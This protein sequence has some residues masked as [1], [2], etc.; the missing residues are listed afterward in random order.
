VKLNS[1]RIL[2]AE[3]LLLDAAKTR[4]HTARILR[5]DKCELSYAKGQMK[6]LY[7]GRKFPSVDVIIPRASIT[8]N[9]DLVLP[10]NK[11]LLLMGVPL[12]NGYMPIMRAKN[13]IRTLQILSHK[14]VPVPQT[15]VLQHL[16]YL[17]DA[18][19][20]VGGFPVVLKT[21]SGSLGKGVVIVESRR[22]LLS[23]LDMILTQEH[24]RILL[25]QE[26]V[27]EAEGKDV[28][29]FVVGRKVVASME[30]TAAAGDFRS[31]IH[32]GGVGQCADL[33]LEEER[34][35]LK[36]TGA[37]GLDFSG[38][39]LLRTKNGPVVIEVNANPGLE[40]ITDATGVDVA[41]AIIDFAVKKVGEENSIPAQEFREGLTLEEQKELVL[42][43]PFAVI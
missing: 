17:D 14:G 26:F 25:V 38:V 24:W 13:K 7:A 42:D 23:A 4:G 11:H 19:K 29:V 3:K 18:I 9:V 1:R 43:E 34:L 30:R 2:K 22:S 40:G 39:D 31:N 12:V 6:V 20:R 21:I 41:G 35:A 5:A 33:S 27:E 32:A 15:V 16:G 37:L 8:I 28:R 36:A 10:L